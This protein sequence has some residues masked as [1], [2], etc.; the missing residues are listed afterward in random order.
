MTYQCVGCDKLF[1]NKGDVNRHINSIHSK[2]INACKIYTKVFNYVSNLRRPLKMV[3]YNIRDYQFELCGRVL[4]QNYE[5]QEHKEAVHLNL[6]Q[7]SM[8]KLEMKVS[9]MLTKNN[10]KFIREKTFN[11]LTGIS[12]G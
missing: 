11:D 12:K 3:R 7:K 1:V 2:Q 8:S 5:S 4:N 6:K 10:N 9:E